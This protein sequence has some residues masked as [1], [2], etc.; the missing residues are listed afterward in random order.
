MKNCSIARPCVV[1]TWVYFRSHRWELSG[2]PEVWI[3]LPRNRQIPT[4]QSSFTLC[5]HF[6]ILRKKVEM[7]F[8][9]KCL[10]NQGPFNLAWKCAPWQLSTSFILAFILIAFCDETLQRS[11]LYLPNWKLYILNADC[12]WSLPVTCSLRTFKTGWEISIPEEILCSFQKV[13]GATLICVM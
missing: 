9:W 1:Y 2:I 11:C 6:Y 5:V 12:K 8:Q 4:C 3:V 10:R 13:T 7:K